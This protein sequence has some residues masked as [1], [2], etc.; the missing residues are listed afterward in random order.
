MFSIQ[1]IYNIFLFTLI[2][3][4]SFSS[5]IPNI[6]LGVLILIFLYR[7]IKKEKVF[8]LKTQYIP[9]ILLFFYLVLK[10]LIVTKFNFEDFNIYSRFLIILILPFL[11]QDESKTKI[12][13]AVVISSFLAILVAV[14]NTIFYFIKYKNLPFENGDVVNK[15]L[16]IDRPYLGFYCLTALILCF[17]LIKKL[18]KYRILLFIVSII[19]STFIML[20]VARLSL[21]TGILLGFVYLLFY[22]EFTIIKKIIIVLSSTLVIG[23]TLFSYKNMTNRFFTNTSMERIK[24]YDPRVDIWD[25]SYKISQENEFNIFLGC[26]SH[27]EVSNKLVECYGT[28]SEN[29]PPRRQW[30]VDT[31][32]NTHSQFI[33]FYLVGGL[34][35]LLLFIYLIYEIIKGSINDFYFFSLVIS[36][37]L[38]LFFENVFQRQLGCY[39]I[40]VILS[41]TSY[42]YKLVKQ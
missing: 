6:C 22:S 20:I 34:I 24:L 36:L 38:F 8:T 11:L 25:C 39:L 18:P 41:L 29:D 13:I 23:I 19:L 15:I 4:L 33:D 21:I 40:G 3:S 42:K 30:F 17:Y 1:K 16:V 5:A 2:I 9:F 12:A 32:F 26:K 10:Q 7:L 31:R 14:F 35:G 37:V 27:Q 28:K